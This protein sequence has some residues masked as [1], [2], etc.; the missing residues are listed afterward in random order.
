MV[1][2]H[3]VHLGSVSGFKLDSRLS[4]FGP[5]GYEAHVLLRVIAEETRARK[6]TG[7]L[8]RLRSSTW[9]FPWTFCCL[10]Y[11]MAKPN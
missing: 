3:W 8:P 11:S 1:E 9:S 4:I 6:S 7:C 5:I 2:L 10:K